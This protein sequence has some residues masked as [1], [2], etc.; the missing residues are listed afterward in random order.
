MI[1]NKAVDIKKENTHTETV[2]E[3]KAAIKTAD[4]QLLKENTT[5]IFHLTPKLTQRTL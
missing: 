4:N 5:N 2:D 1:S 3:A